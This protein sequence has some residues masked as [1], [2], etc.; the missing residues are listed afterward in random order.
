MRIRVSDDLERAIEMFSSAEEESLE[1]YDEKGKTIGT[2]T[3]DDMKEIFQEVQSHQSVG[4]II[5]KFSNGRHTSQK[6][7][8]I[9]DE[10]SELLENDVFT[11][12]INSLYDGVFITDGYGITVKINTAYERITNLKPE[13]LIGYHMEEI[14]KEGYISKSASIQVIK[15]KKPVTLMQTIHNGRKIIVSGTP[16]FNEKKEILY[17]INSVRDI[18]ELLKLKLRI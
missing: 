14:I 4:E 3:L 5:Q 7:T 10:Y 1:V 6:R 17:V 9:K 18:T 13:Q 11:D 12:I 16:I 2:L 8:R 15:E